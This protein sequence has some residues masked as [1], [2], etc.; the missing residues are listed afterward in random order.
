MQ[1]FIENAEPRVVAMMLVGIVLLVS[2]IE[3]TYL[4][5][6]Q[7]KSFRTLHASHQV[8]EQA[9]TS[10]DSLSNQLQKIDAEV[11]DLSHQLHGDMAR[12]PAKQMESFVIGRLQKVS[13]A[14]Q[15]ELLSVQPGSGNQVQNFRESLFEVKLNARYHDFF[16]WLQTVNHELGYIVVK[17]FEIRPDERDALQNPELSLVLTLVSYRMVQD[18]AS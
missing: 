9:V 1:D 10:D 7:V 4:L 11:Q 2:I 18:Y 15:V 6:P 8:L 14:T 12:L 17:K 5:W 13:W 16:E 3:V